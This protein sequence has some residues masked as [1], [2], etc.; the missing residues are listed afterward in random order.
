M[1]N[2]GK[3]PFNVT[4]F[5]KNFP[6]AHRRK[7]QTYVINEICEA[8]NSGYKHILLEAPTG[9][10]KSPVAIAVA[11][12]MGS[13]YICTS[14]KDLQTQ[15]SRDFSFLKV[16]KGA[17]NFRCLVKEDFIRNN[18]YRC[19]V[20]ASDTFEECRH[21]SVE[22]GPCMTNES[23][24]DRACKYRTFARDYKV[25]NKGTKDEQ[26]FINR[27]DEI[28][29]QKEF[30]QWLH[31]KNLKY[32]K[33]PREWKPCEY[34]N[35]LNIALSSS[36]SIFNYSNFLAFL[37]NPKILH[38]REL[39]VLDE[40]H[41]L[42]TEIVKFRGLSLSKRRWKRYIQDLQMVDYGYDN[43]EQ[44][45]EFL[46]EL[47]TRMLTLI[48]NTS[49]IELLALQRKIK[50]GLHGLDGVGKGEYG[51]NRTTESKKKR[52]TSA[53]T[54]YESDDEI[55]QKYQENIS[56]SSIN[57][58]EELAADA[59]RDTERLM[60]TINNILS[61]PR[62]WIISE[63]KKE[64]H[65]VIKVELKPLDISPYCEHVFDKC[66]KVLIMSATILNPKAFCRSVGLISDKEVKFIQIKSDFPIEN[67]PIYPMNIAYL[68]FNNLQL[69]DIKSS[70]TKT[71]DNIM[72]IHKKDKGIVH[73][74][75][76]EQLNFIKEKISQENARRLLVTDPEIQRD[77][78]IQEHINSIKPTVLI[79][80]SLH[81]GLDLKGELSR[82][83]IITKVPYPNKNDR[84]INAKRNLDEDWY[85]WQTALKL[86]QASGRSIRSK[87]DWAKT[88]ILD[89]AFGYFVNKNKN[90]LPDWF[91][92]AVK[93]R[94]S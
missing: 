63:I 44:W 17:N 82:F 29:Y 76:Y 89:S 48:G 91:M 58:S 60:I 72:T 27:S 11:M 40:G 75:S 81:T 54:L 90:I 46:I 83:Q 19:G 45:I 59:I 13:S 23:F 52:I 73:T 22:Y 35:Q 38:P 36:H 65:E 55:A 87:E 51:S 18:T 86:L 68:N 61:N 49:M 69:P 66:S 34:F 70:I 14:T 32:V 33:E 41:S 24:Q 71:I 50:F 78:I 79:S 1:S 8:F 28:N 84:W 93:G 26:I 15:Y 4:D 31:L 67:R 10:G 53:S 3:S 25:T 74:T 92:Q 56:I 43:L 2:Q 6:F 37:P 30:L 57:I 80:P 20:C 5:I 88:Y 85:Y 62:N 77:E 12:T 16:A 47:E 7:S 39:L 94:S 64:G 42:E 9:F 21:T